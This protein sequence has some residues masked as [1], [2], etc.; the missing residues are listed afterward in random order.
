MPP[1]PVPTL[2]GLDPLDAPE[3]PPPEGSGL[4]PE[5]EHAAKA[6]LKISKN[7]P[8]YPNDRGFIDSP[9]A[10]VHARDEPDFTRTPPPA[11]SATRRGA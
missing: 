3:P 1:S 6:A 10:G 5:A 2:T 11:G 4:S 9:R 8:A 7:A